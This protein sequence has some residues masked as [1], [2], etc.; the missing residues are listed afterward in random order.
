MLDLPLRSGT[1]GE[2][3]GPGIWIPI[4]SQ[5]THYNLRVISSIGP[6]E[7]HLRVGCVLNSENKWKPNKAWLQRPVTVLWAT[8]LFPNRVHG[9]WDKARLFTL[10]L[11][12][13]FRLQTRSL[14]PFQSCRSSKDIKAKS[15]LC[16]TERCAGIR[17][18]RQTVASES[19][20]RQAHYRVL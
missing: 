3:E 14:L 10:E 7:N 5:V 8:G 12:I 17:G 19:K 9:V 15:S 18:K 13:I 1:C 4:S 2:G 20:A 11:W 16:S 6:F